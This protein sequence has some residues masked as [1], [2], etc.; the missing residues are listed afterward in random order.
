[1]NANVAPAPAAPVQQAANEAPAPQRP[2][3][4]PEPPAQAAAAAPPAAAPAPRAPA[5]PF[6]PKGRF[7]TANA[8]PVAPGLSTL[9]EVAAPAPWSTNEDFEFSTFVPN[10]DAASYAVHLC[11]QEISTTDRFTRAHPHWLPRISQIYFAMLYYFRTFDCMVASG[12]ADREIT[13]LLQI[14]KQHFDFRR[15][16][17]PG[18]L[19]PY[20]QAIS[21]CSSG[22]DLLG[23][24]VPVVPDLHDH[25][26]RARFYSLGYTGMP[27][28][29][30]LLDQPAYYQHRYTIPAAPTQYD[31]TAHRAVSLHRS[32][33]AQ[34]NAA[35]MNTVLSS[36][37]HSFPT[38][39]SQVQRAV[40]KTAAA[41]RLRLP[42][43]INLANVTDARKL[44]WP[45]VLRLIPVPG[46]TT[47]PAF[48]LWFANVAALM[49]DY[50]NF[51]AHSTSLADIPTSSGAAPLVTGQYLDSADP[52]FRPGSLGTLNATHDAIELHEW[53][54][55]C[56]TAEVRAPSVPDAHIQLGVT[57]Q[58]NVRRHSD[59]VANYRT[60]PVWNMSPVRHRMTDFD[61]FTNLPIY[62]AA[63]NL[64]TSTARA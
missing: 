57:T 60:G 26:V 46:E 51:F 36:P 6:A 59:T 64:E 37:G 31:L 47:S 55:L 15:L 2:A 48:R 30:S 53:T 11:D 18:P 3:A 42:D 28:I 63:F 4:A 10:F 1:M 33:V 21:Y 32:A 19:V 24:V 56:F 43:Q 34:A 13:L 14:L 39:L 23:D 52:L 9:L 54:S 20:F 29:L 35:A 22:H 17:I 5:V 16:R 61:T 7:P 25:V 8:G 27:N 44:S 50:A 45:Q 38:G 41:T 12:Y 40:F 58:I 49:S 62:V